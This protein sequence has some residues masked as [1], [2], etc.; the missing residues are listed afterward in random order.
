MTKTTEN[1]DLVGISEVTKGPIHIYT[2]NA[3]RYDQQWLICWIWIE[4]DWFPPNKILNVFFSYCL[5]LKI[6]TERLGADWLVIDIVKRGQ[7]WVTESIINCRIH[8][9][10]VNKTTEKWPKWEI[11]FNDLVFKT[12]G[13]FYQLYVGSDQTRAISPANPVLKETCWEI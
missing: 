6:K 5:L 12:E 8:K 11:K 4:H 3:K 9:V 1:G 13:Y 10:N 7:V 2:A